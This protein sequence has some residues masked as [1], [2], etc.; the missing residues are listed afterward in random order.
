[1][2]TSVLDGRGALLAAKV[3]VSTPVG[4][5]PRTDAAPGA[6]APRSDASAI[7]PRIRG[8]SGRR[9]WRACPH[10]R[11]SLPPGWIGFE[12]GRALEALFRKSVRVA[13]DVA[14]KGVIETHPVPKWQ[15]SV[16]PSG[17]SGRRADRATAAPGPRVEGEVVRAG[18][19]G[20]PAA[21]GRVLCGLMAAQ[22][23]AAPGLPTEEAPRARS[24]AVAPRRGRGPLA[25]CDAR[26]PK[27]PAPPRVSRGYS[28]DRTRGHAVVTM[29]A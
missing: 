1:M 11:E 7:R 26:L 5:H 18:G 6:R 19:R 17:T 16:R 15:S 9:G 4:E 25:Q 27:L 12:L 13:N 28:S 22:G 24:A 10:R 23:I 29:S 20:S 8:L 21:S 14:R 3:Q 2:K